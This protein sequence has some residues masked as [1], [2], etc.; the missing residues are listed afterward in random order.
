MKT[1]NK[2]LIAVC[3]TAASCATFAQSTFYGELDYV[4][5]RYSEP[6]ISA[7]PSSLRMIYG[8]KSSD[9]LSYE[10]LLA[11]G[12]STGNTQY[13]T[14]NFGIKENSVIGFYAKG[15]AKLSDSVQVFGR[16]GFTRINLT[17]SASGPGVSFQQTTSGGS[18][19]YG[20][21]LN[22]NVDATSSVNVDYMAYY[23]RDGVSL[24][25]LG[26]GYQRAF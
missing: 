26:L 21:G 19:S 8:V 5:G 1:F 7:N 24:N 16:F 10:G 22:F 18:L 3:L 25:G 14:V 17:D 12:L 9:T 6:L 13:R 4:S 23:N 2:S 11:L 20:A 15:T